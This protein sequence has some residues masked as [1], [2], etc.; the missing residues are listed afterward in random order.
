[1]TNVKAGRKYAM[2]YRF[3]MLSCQYL[4]NSKSNKSAGNQRLVTGR[5]NGL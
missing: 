2:L 4:H 3:T 1:M 5:A